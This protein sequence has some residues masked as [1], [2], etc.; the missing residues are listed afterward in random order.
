M[1]TSVEPVLEIDL[2][3]VTH[4]YDYLS[5]LAQ[6]AQIACAVKD[7]AYGIGAKNVVRAL[8]GRCSTFFVAYVSEGQI[9]RSAAPEA[10]IYVLQGVGTQ[11]LPLLKAYRLTPVLSSLPDVQWWTSITDDDYA[12]MI[13]TGL[14]RLGLRPEEINALTSL[15]REKT[16]L[17]L[18]HLSCADDPT[19]PL[20]DLQL[21]R[22]QA[23]KSF[24]PNARFSLSA[25]E[26][27]LL[28]A[29]YLQDMVRIGA[30]LYGINRSEAVKSS[31]RPVMSV[32]A[33]VLQTAILPKGESVS[34]GAVFKAEKEMRLAVVGLGYGDGLFRCLGEGK[35]AFYWQERRLPVLG[36]ICMDCTMCDITSAP[37]IKPG[38]FVDVLNAF[39]TADEMAV[40]ADTIGYEIIS[41]FGKGLR[42]RR[43]V[44][45]TS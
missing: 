35:G 8:K 32:K 3:A 39:Y 27:F 38:D 14:N 4:N 13:E 10:E 2:G 23:L 30:L 15:Q 24:F 19:H 40:D 33:A 7:D 17:V 37:D 16:T 22:F 34:Y 21:A 6:K 5:K 18:S 28:G 31:I 9:V 45:E 20:N 25:S 42:F 26:G 12:L 1:K 11:D 44:K 36:R 29:S 41:R 43:L